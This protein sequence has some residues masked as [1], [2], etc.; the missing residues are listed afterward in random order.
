MSEFYKNG[1]ADGCMDWDDEIS[2]D[3]EE[4]ITLPE[5]DYVFEVVDFERGHYPG[6]TKIPACN[7]AELT[8]KVKT[9]DGVASARVD[10]IMYRSLEWKISSFFRSIGMKQKG[11]KV[12]MKW[13]SIIGCRGRAHFKPRV[14]TAKDGNERT[15]NDVTRFL[16][17]DPAMMP[18]MT[19]EGFVEVDESEGLPLD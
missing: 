13:N 12:V 11:E 3:G 18:G 4:Y 19:P 15:A 17:F 10:L 2:N 5:G 7:K 8:L 9:D 1:A 14:Y 16:D 6:S